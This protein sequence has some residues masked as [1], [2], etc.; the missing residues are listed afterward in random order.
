MNIIPR[1]DPNYVDWT[2]ICYYLNNNEFTLRGQNINI[3][4]K[5][6]RLG[7]NT[8]LWR[9][10]MDVLEISNTDSEVSNYVFANNAIYID[11]CFNFYL[12][13]QDP[14]NVNGLYFD[15]SDC[16]I[17]CNSELTDDCSKSMD[18]ST[19]DKWFLGDR[20]SMAEKNPSDLEYND[21]EYEA[22]C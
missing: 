15:G 16:V 3:P 20:E 18:M 6:A 7:V 12:K 9:D 10:A 21:P 1:D 14:Y 13:R 8:Y 22:L 11:K 5:A 17:E 19:I 2:A 4:E